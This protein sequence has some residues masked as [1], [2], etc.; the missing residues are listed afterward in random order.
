L[1]VCFFDGQRMRPGVI[2]ARDAR[3]IAEANVDLAAEA[4]KVAQALKPSLDVG[5]CTAR[6]DALVRRLTVT[7]HTAREKAASL[8]AAL[9][10]REGFG[11]GEAH[12]LDAV[13][14]GKK[15]SCQGLSLLYLCAARRL[16]VPARLVAAP[17]HLFLQCGE[18]EGRFFVETT[19]KGALH[20]ATHYLR[21]HLGEQRMGEAGGIHLQPLSMPQAVGVLAEELGRMLRDLERYPE[22]LRHYARAIEVNP[23]HAEA[24]VGLGAVLTGLGKLDAAAEACAKAAELNPRDPE[25]HCYWGVALRRLGRH[26]EA[27][28]HYAKAVELRRR[29]DKAYCNW[30]VALERMGK[31]QEACDKYGKATAL[32]PRNADAHFNWGVALAK[33]EQFGEACDR[34]VRADALKPRD[35]ATAFYWGV[36]LLKVGKRAEGVGKL[37]AA[38]ALSPD[39]KP[40]VDEILGKLGSQ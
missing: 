33:L 1:A 2:R 30:G 26:A 23:R 21:Q 17:E 9:F 39:F 14:D 35:A 7:G 6:L 37:K 10:E 31:H 24:W 12:T 40:Q 15:G 25:A 22:A 27:C 29:F 4:L 38:A 28:A 34:F 36:S 13:L 20:D 16:G 5:A 18:G 11:P 32:N 19:R 8:A 3:A